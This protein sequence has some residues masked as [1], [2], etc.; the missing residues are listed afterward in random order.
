MA[1]TDG[2]RQLWEHYKVRNDQAAYLKLYEMYAP[3]SRVVARDVFRR[4]QVNDLEWGDYVQNASIGLLEAMVRY[5][6]VRGTDFMAYA[7][8]RVRG[9]VFNGLRS[10][11][12]QVNKRTFH[13][14]WYA[15]RADS[16]ISRQSDTGLDGLISQVTGLAIGLL[17]DFSSDQEP[18]SHSSD[19]VRNAEQLQI[20]SL[21]AESLNVLSKNERFVIEAHYFQHTSFV[22]IAGLLGLT[23][24][25]VSQI[26]GAA[27]GKMK[28]AVRA[29]RSP[30]TESA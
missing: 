11:L 20:E 6:H 15:D 10:S 8:P 25:R 26:H 29:N 18:H 19:P 1:V 21:L 14:D 27:I 16:I 24:G 30:R 28:A 2:E 23:K 22:N 5:D 9:A 13:V 12:S 7:K 3:W 17:L 4:I